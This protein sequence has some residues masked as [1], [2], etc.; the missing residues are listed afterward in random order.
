MLKPE[1][2]KILACPGCAG[3]LKYQAEPEKLICPN[4][5]LKFTVDRGIP[6]ILVEQ[7]EKF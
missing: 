5:R 3:S 2:L 7:A 1:L 6:V 4:C